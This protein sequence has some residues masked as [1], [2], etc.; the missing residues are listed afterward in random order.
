MLFL[1]RFQGFVRH[2]Y[3]R[4]TG[5]QNSNLSKLHE[6]NRRRLSFESLLPRLCR[7]NDP[8]LDFGDAPD[9]NYE[10]TTSPGNYTS[11]YGPAHV[12]GMLRL[13]TN[14][15]AEVNANLLDPNGFWPAFLIG[16][17]ASKMD[18]S[19]NYLQ[20]A[21]EDGVK[22]T[23]LP[24]PNI[25]SP[26]IASIDVTVMGASATA[27]LNAWADFNR[28][29][30]FKDTGEQVVLNRIVNNGGN[31]INYA[32]PA[33]ITAG[34]IY[35]RFRLSSTAG[36]NSTGFSDSGV[37]LP[38]PD[39]EVE[40][41][42]IVIGND[43]RID[44]A[45]KS[46]SLF[47]LG[48]G[49]FK[50]Q[51]GP[52]LYDEQSK[53][54]F[55]VDPYL[56]SFALRAMLAAPPVSG[57]DKFASAISH[58]KFWF[59]NIQRSTLVASDRNATFPRIH[60]YADGSIL[61]K[62]TSYLGSVIQPI[63]GADADDSALAVQLS[64]AEDFRIAGGPLSELTSRRDT[65]R[66]IANSLANLI[67]FNRLPVPFVDPTNR[68]QIQQQMDVLEVWE[69]LVK[70]ASLER[71]LFGDLKRAAE[72]QAKADL[73]KAA[74]IQAYKDPASGL[75]RQY[76]TAK[77][78]V[79]KFE[80]DKWYPFVFNQVFP[81][82]T[83]F[84][85]SDS[86]EAKTLLNGVFNF[87]NGSDVRYNYLDHSD[88]AF[89]ALA[90]LKVGDVERAKAIMEPVYQWAWNNSVSNP[91]YVEPGLYSIANY[92]YLVFAL[93]PQTNDDFVTTQE[94]TD[95]R[96]N[97]TANDYSLSTP[98]SQLKVT[99]AVPPKSG[100]VISVSNG[101]ISYKPNPNFVGTD[102]LVYTVTDLT[103][104]KRTGVLNVKINARPKISVDGKVT[105]I[106]NSLPILVAGNAIV[107]DADHLAAQGTLVVSN[108]DSSTPQDRLSIRSIG[109]GLGQI[110]ITGSTIQM[111]SAVIG[112]FTGGV[113]GSP[114][115]IRFNAN[116][117]ISS[118]Q[119]VAQSIS[120]EVQGDKPNFPSRRLIFRLD[121]GDGGTSQSVNSTV[122]ITIVSV[123]DA[124]VVS[125]VGPQVHYNSSPLPVMFANSA[126]IL[127]A[128]N[129]IFGSA[130]IKVALST[131]DSNDRLI[132]VPNTSSI[133][134]IS[135]IGNRIFQKGKMIAS[136]SGGTT[137][138]PLQIA[139]ING[140]TP[141]IV[142]SVLR[143][144]GFTNSSASPT[145]VLRTISIEVTDGF[146]GKGVSQTQLR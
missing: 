32:V 107:S 112:T 91:E 97:V 36:L 70:Y 119:K 136:Y 62:P 73:V 116:T 81:I 6:S 104:A 127:D 69:G 5:F 49:V 47:A 110:N 94:N 29:G 13:G 68:Y 124:P 54:V 134:D 140:L 77:G 115:T 7:E 26:S 93:L 22:F 11:V 45:I 111:S 135:L 113:G 82:T 88:G 59:S 106:E 79:A 130:L 2:F 142:Q 66:L 51:Y 17:N 128:D 39:G 8:P 27:Y 1:I 34:S 12:I 146:G 42:Q 55:Q 10:L 4:I 28:D 139:F 144:I 138:S 78:D 52:A 64:L 120:F 96:F 48:N 37:R 133:D 14:V 76:T 103:G 38:L 18:G 40:D 56:P 121:D 35:Y 141:Q 84:I 63:I 15:D 101:Y 122:T 24:T 65:F 60:V 31:S 90:T 19:G 43:G 23:L 61:P 71:N 46:I 67:K 129:Q 118:I 99:V 89:L 125:G 137:S 58:F 25:H 85:S 108:L 105:Y 109:S 3:R 30:D 72:F 100:R 126:T 50:S 33:Q 98:S 114:L 74:A 143:R 123:N 41:Y 75:Y 83:Q 20:A 53:P 44:E 80:M 95:I 16:D 145:T 87:W 117:P 92:G 57:I 132:I 21:D 9:F 131:S 86:A 102:S